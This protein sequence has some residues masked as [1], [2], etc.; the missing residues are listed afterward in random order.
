[1]RVPSGLQREA[2]ELK[3][4]DRPMIYR[5]FLEGLSPRGIAVGFREKV[6][7][8]WDAEHMTPRL[9]W[10]GAFIDA[11]KHWVDRGPGNQTPLGDHI[12]TLPAG[13]P[14][15]QLPSLDQ[16]WPDKLPRE[17]G[18]R[19]QG[20]RLSAEG[21]PTFRYQMGS[22]SVED[23]IQPLESTPDNGLERKMTFR[24]DAPVKDLFVRLAVGREVE[25]SS[26]AVTIDGVRFET[27]GVTPVIRTSNGQSELLLPISW[28]GDH[29]SL[30]VRLRW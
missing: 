5:N 28:Q 2:I 22:I 21:I 10:H 3:P 13:P 7:F 24:S 30:V 25:E 27:D 12:M 20:Y 14:L 19:F 8:A 11:S 23:F 18:F 16:P 29:A 15:A 17:H 26:D 6:H 9:I 4:T 1:A